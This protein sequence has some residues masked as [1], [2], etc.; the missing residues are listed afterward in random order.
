MTVG[1]GV[2]NAAAGLSA[3][4]FTWSTT[5]DNKSYLNDAAM[6]LQ[7]SST[8]GTTPINLDINFGS[9][10]SLS[11][12]AV[13]GHNLA[14]WSAPTITISAAD[15]SSFTVN[16]VTAKSATTVTLTAPNN[17]DTLLQFPSVSRQYWRLAFNDGGATRTALIGEVLCLATITSLTRSPAYGASETEEYVTNRAEL[18]T[19]NVRSSYLAGPIRT[20]KLPFIDLSG[21][22]QRDE[23]MAM[24]RATRGGVSNLLWVFDVDSSASAGDADSQ[25]C[26]WGKVQ[27]TMG[28]VEGDYRLYTVDG[29]E[30]RQ[31]GRVVGT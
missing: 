3:S 23:L 24:F 2:T 19:G 11:A 4:A 25:A 5:G 14:S 21:T 6:D 1:Y 9:A 8:S 15:N 29:L 28:W 16:N 10:T 30:L 7:S 17:R 20:L 18:R 12:I 22:S 26:V 31:V 27:Q 13:L